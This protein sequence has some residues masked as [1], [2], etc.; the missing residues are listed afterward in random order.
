MPTRHAGVHA[1]F[2]RIVAQIRTPR[3]ARQEY[4]HRTLKRHHSRGAV[5]AEYHRANVAR[6]EFVA[7][8][9]FPRCLDELVRRVLHVHPVNLARVVHPLE[10]L[11]QAKNRRPLRR[12]VTT[13]AFENGRAEL[14]GVGQ[15]VERC[16]FPRH[17]FTVAPNPF[18]LT[19]FAHTSPEFMCRYWFVAYS[20]AR[21]QPPS[22]AIDCAVM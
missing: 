9:Q 14:H 10:M 16:V 12:V 20:S 21:I 18:R 2:E 15:H 11:A 1:F 3:P 13:D 6:F 5:A 7:A 17:E 19:D 22:T 8:Y 4:L